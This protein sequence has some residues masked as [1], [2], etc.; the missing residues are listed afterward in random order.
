VDVICTYPPSPAFAGHR[1][2]LVG[3]QSAGASFQTAISGSCHDSSL[4]TVC[5]S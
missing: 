4:R 2:N 3:S 5:Q 1:G